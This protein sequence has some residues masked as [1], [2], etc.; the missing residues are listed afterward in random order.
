MEHS[1][2]LVELVFLLLMVLFQGY[3]ARFRPNLQEA[4]PTANYTKLQVV[5]TAKYREYQA[6]LADLGRT[7]PKKPASRSTP[8]VEDTA[9]VAAAAAAAAA[10]ADKVAPLKIRISSRGKK[11]K[12]DDSDEDRKGFYWSAESRKARISFKCLILILLKFILFPN[13]FN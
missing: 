10:G 5:L 1:S 11:K 4:N 8:K 12:G 7:I 9:A 6:H 13:I 3:A 2:T